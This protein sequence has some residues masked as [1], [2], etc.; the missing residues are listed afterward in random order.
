[1]RPWL[2]LANS[3]LS[4]RNGFDLDF[5]LLISCL[6]LLGLGL[7]M[8]TSA[9]MDVAA[10]NNQNPDYYTI[11]HS[12]FLALGLAGSIVVL[13][14]PLS[15]WQRHAQRLL[16]L[17]VFL[18]V[19]VLIPG[20]GREV[21]GS[22]RWITLGAINLQV[23]E[24]AKL[25][26]VLYM[27]DYLVR[28][29]SNVRSTWLGIWLPM[30]V[31]GVQ[32]VLLLLEPDFGALVVLVGT[33]IVMLFL[34]GVSLW[35]FLLITAGVAVVGGAAMMAEDYRKARLTN[36]T[37]PWADPYGDGYQLTQALIAFGRGDWLGQGLGESVQ[38][39]FFLPE[40]HTDF[41]FSILAEEL[42]LVGSV[43]TVA[44][45]MYLCLRCW[46]IAMRAELCHQRFSA[47]LAYG[48]G[49]LWIA[50]FLINV[51]VNT[52]L[53]PTKGLTLPFLSYGG[54]SL[55]VC[56]LMLGLLLRIDWETRNTPAISPDIF[57]AADFAE[58]ERRHGR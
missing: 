45:F 7:V 31:L 49:T 27:A 55:I 15:I 10:V 23:S 14:V 53:L 4:L 21:N 57:T 37:D 16:L 46:R 41:V 48:L 1:M 30:A 24:L 8:V 58:E 28:R 44:L 12:I 52:G 51:G 11:R 18:L 33:G 19:L 54:S 38:K 6:V 22:Q 42:G 17:G 25:F 2:R 26:T 47:G 32:A 3:P 5:P 43:A 20:I 36:F 56:C 9:S 29:E 40:A 35:R 39:Q 13:M 34:G 50:Q